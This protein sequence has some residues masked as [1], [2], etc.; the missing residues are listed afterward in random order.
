M[1]KFLAKHKKKFI[2]SFCGIGAFYTLFGFFGVPLLIEKAVPKILENEANFSVKSAKFNPFTYELNITAPSLSTFKPLFSAEKIDVKL[3]FGELFNKTIDIQT[4]RLQSPKISISRENN[5]SFN[6]ESLYANS[7]SEETDENSSI[8]V[9]LDNFKIENGGVFYEDLSLKRPFKIELG[10]LNYE[11]AGLNLASNSIGNHDFN[12]SSQTFDNIFHSGSISLNPLKIEGNLSVENL[13]INPFWLS[14]LD[15]KELDLLGGKISANALYKVILDEEIALNLEKSKIALN[16]L[17]LLAS[18]NLIKS[19]QISLANIDFDAKFGENLTATLG[20]G[21]IALKNSD[22]L[23]A[24]NNASLGEFKAFDFGLKFGL[25]GENLGLNANLDK[26]NLSECKFNDSLINLNAKGGEISQISANFKGENNASK[27]EAKVAKIEILPLNLALAKF[28]KIDLANLSADDFSFQMGEKGSNLALNLAKFGELSLANKNEKFSGIKN[29]SVQKLNFALD[30]LA[31]NIDKIGI[32][33][34]FFN[35][36]ISEEGAKSIN[37]LSVISY[38]PSKAENAKFS[39][40]LRSAIHTLAPEGNFTQNSENNGSARSISPAKNEPKFSFAIAQI[41]LNGG[42]AKITESFVATQMTHNLAK[43][44]ASVQNLSS[45]FSTPFSAKVS[46]A[47]D[48]I[49][50]NATSK[51]TINPLN[52][53]IDFDVAHPDLRKVNPYLEQFLNAKIASGSANLKGNFKFSDKFTLNAEISGKNL[54]LNDAKG[55][56]IFSINSAKVGALS[57]NQSKIDI[58]NIAINAPYAKIHIAKNGEINL[59]K[60]AKTSPKSASKSPAPKT[61]AMGQKSTFGVNIAN[62]SVQNGSFNFIDDTLFMPLNITVSK[63]KTTIDKISDKSQ[64]NLKFNGLVGKSGLGQ[65]ALRAYPFAP[66]QK[67]DISVVLKDVAL[68]DITPYSAK[69]VGYE[70]K[71][72]KSNLKL[73]Y[74][75]NA[76]KLNATNDIN[77]DNLVLGEKVESKDALDLPLDLAISILK[78]SDGQ[79]NVS[80]PI[81]GNLNDPKFSFGGVIVGA[82]TKLFSDI[83]LSPFRFLGKIAGIDT[84]SLDGIDFEPASSE[85]LISENE[86]I[87]NLATI[88]K[89]KPEIKITLTPAYNEKLDTRAFKLVTL[90]ENIDR[91]MLKENLSS[92]AAIASLRAKHRINE[93]GEEGFEK[94]IQAQKFTTSRLENLAVERAKSVQNA[95]ANLGVSDSQI[96]IKKP[97]NVSAKQDSFISVGLGVEK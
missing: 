64:A 24:E 84:S 90:N 38:A 2:Y 57:L 91:L 48:E 85:I 19:E 22:F 17:A 71:S 33:A 37:D 36:E 14:F 44:D 12:A 83:V 96:V 72:G 93:S 59:A 68:S 94:L 15:I 49:S 39:Q 56:K 21:E 77:L 79:I 4:L 46:L 42:H 82:V 27:T 20:A 65:I 26:I 76:S 35:S 92:D 47:S 87:E 80:L 13:K 74:K 70:I 31:L 25:E 10:S 43:I 63:I 7:Q 28:D 60:L 75:I 32:D 8:N 61:Q 30:K 50:A 86:K 41:A 23:S 95:L 97:A 3:K 52:L 1:V 78:D 88:A 58:K 6:F 16:D 9:K 54:A 66:E 73:N 53:D 5:G 67:S 11:I 29:L 34:P 89:S 45:N 81:S 69:F 40:N 18:Q 51:I 62:L 55:A